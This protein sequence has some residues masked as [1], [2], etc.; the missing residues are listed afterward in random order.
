M[1]DEQDGGGIL[2]LAEIVDT[3]LRLRVNGQVREIKLLTNEGL[4]AL[5][6][7]VK[8]RQMKPLA[9]KA[10][11]LE[12][13]EDIKRRFQSFDMNVDQIAQYCFNVTQGGSRHVLELAMKIS[14]MKD[15]EINAALD[16]LR[17]QLG[18]QRF[19][20]LAAEVS[21]VFPAQLKPRPKEE[22]TQPV[23]QNPTD[24]STTGQTTSP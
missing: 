24:T 6:A 20:S 11:T 2:E 14:G 4:V 16:K 15:D 13:I 10:K 17:L 18:A 5:V 8:Q 1:S 22:G 23:D 12:E 19:A 9:E 21:G 7:E 3:P